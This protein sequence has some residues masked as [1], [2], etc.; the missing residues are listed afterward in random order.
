MNRTACAGC[1]EQVISG[2]GNCGNCE[3]P[4]PQGARAVGQ[5]VA[6]NKAAAGVA[7][8]WVVAAGMLVGV[9][10]LFAFNANRADATR[11][12]AA[13]ELASQAAT[14]KQSAAEASYRAK[15]LADAKAAR[16]AARVDLVQQCASA[17]PAW[18]L[19]KLRECIAGGC[20]DTILNVILDSGKTPKETRDLAGTAGAL[21]IQQ[22]VSGTQDGEKIDNDH[23]DAVV[24]VVKEYGN[25]MYSKTPKTSLGEVAKDPDSER[26]KQISA[27]GSVVE[28]HK[29][30]ELFDGAIYTDGAT[31]IR[32]VTPFPTPGI[33][34]GTHVS[35][36]GIFAQEYAY[37]NVSG[38]QTRSL[39][40]VGNLVKDW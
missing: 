18:R 12:A 31:I 21:L 8:L 1:G 2:L 38:G 22:A 3:R 19:N 7:L 6:R 15:V 20:T 25:D 26:G 40:V 16:E 5:A 29:V 13:A 37:S 32:F 11:V 24:R 28:I 34:K 14:I 9:G 10:S 36:R 33:V 17:A 23:V 39:L 30:G 4:V 27:Q 35:L